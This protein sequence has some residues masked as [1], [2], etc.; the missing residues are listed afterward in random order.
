MMMKIFYNIFTLALLFA[1]SGCAKDENDPNIIEQQAEGLIGTAL[2][3]HQNSPQGLNGL[4]ES[5]DEA[6][7]IGVNLFGMA[8]EWQELETTPNTFAFQDFLINP[9]TLLDPDET[10][11]KNYIL[12]LKMIDSNRKTVPSDLSG[13]SFDDTLLINRFKNLIDNMSALPEINRISHILIGNEVDGYLTTNASEL[14]AFS[15][16]YEQTV[17]HIHTKIP[18]V[19]V[20]T[21]ITY[22]SVVENPIIFETLNPYSDF[23]CYTYYPTDT[24]NPNWQMRLPTEASSDILYMAEKAG[25]KPFA[26]TE[27]GYPSSAENNSSELKQ[28]QFVENMFETLKPYKDIGKLEFLF[29]HGMYDYQPD[30]CVEYAQSQGIDDTYLCG[31]M[32]NLGLKSYATGQAKQSWNTFVNELSDW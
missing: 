6:T 4:L 2:Q 18:F 3:L 29:Y 26:F 32:N 24:T 5:I 23:I 8:P 19:K 9:L 27:I 13:N 17:N 31:F 22:N 15:V 16:F 12:V 11:F 21:I 14:N 20:G 25:D 30:F 1:M 28:S 7:A 10:K